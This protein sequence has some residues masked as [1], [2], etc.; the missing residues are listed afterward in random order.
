MGYLRSGFPEV[1]N[2][3]L[4]NNNL[5]ILQKSKK[6]VNFK[7]LLFSSHNKNLSCDVVY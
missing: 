3:S 7:I 6:Q 4:D 2:S 5:Y 1:R